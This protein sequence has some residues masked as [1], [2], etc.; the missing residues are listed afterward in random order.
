[1]KTNKREIKGGKHQDQQIKTK[2]KNKG[3]KIEKNKWTKENKGYRV[4]KRG[5]T[6]PLV[7]LCKLHI[8]KKFSRTQ[9]LFTYDVKHS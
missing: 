7:R 6:C 3:N 4:K 8:K 5:E 9:E 1:M 2:R